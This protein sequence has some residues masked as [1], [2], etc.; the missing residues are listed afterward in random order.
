LIRG[1]P[2]PVVDLASVLGVDAGKATRFVVVRAGERKVAVAV[3]AVDGIQQ[4]DSHRLGSMP[5][6]LSKA[7]P[8]II[9]AIGALDKELLLVLEAACLVPQEAWASLTEVEAG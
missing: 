1:E 4:A 9:K 7:Q 3:Q 6:L 5:P 8:G 2:L